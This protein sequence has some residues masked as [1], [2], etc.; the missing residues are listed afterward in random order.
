MTSK[1]EDVFQSVTN[2]Y[3]FHRIYFQTKTTE[4]PLTKWTWNEHHW[5]KTSINNLRSISGIFY[6]DLFL[7]LVQREKKKAKWSKSRQ[8]HDLQIADGQRCFARIP[9]RKTTRNG[10]C[11]PAKRPPVRNERSIL[12][13]QWAQFSTGVC[14]VPRDVITGSQQNNSSY[15]RVKKMFHVRVADEPQCIPAPVIAFKVEVAN[16]KVRRW[17][18]WKGFINRR[19]Q[20]RKWTSEKTEQQVTRRNELCHDSLTLSLAFHFDALRDTL[21]AT[22]CSVDGFFKYRVS[23]RSWYFLKTH[24]HSKR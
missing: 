9:S 24:P 20:G 18:V 17:G 11:I 1:R 6:R 4:C 14:N 19:Y 10:R 16:Y 22:G 2:C 15:A 21:H 12:I 7:P 5:Y 23:S 3:R 13:P 8:L